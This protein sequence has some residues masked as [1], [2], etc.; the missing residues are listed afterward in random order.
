MAQFLVALIG[1]VRR[2]LTIWNRCGQLFWQERHPGVG[3]IDG[4]YIDIHIDLDLRVLILGMYV[5]M[6]IYNFYMQEISMFCCSPLILP[7][8][9]LWQHCWADVCPARCV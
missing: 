2:I 8:V 3:E 9:G 1:S 7:R 5:F 4:P 6:Y